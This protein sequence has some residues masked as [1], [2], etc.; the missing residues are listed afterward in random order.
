M[1]GRGLPIIEEI[2]QELKRLATGSRDASKA[3]VQAALE[4]R[5][6]ETQ[7]MWARH[8]TLHEHAADALAAAVAGLESDLIRVAIR[9]V[10]GMGS[11]QD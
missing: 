1:V 8:G 10:A 5:F 9:A 6:P 3:E 2:P 7:A 11:G 4:L